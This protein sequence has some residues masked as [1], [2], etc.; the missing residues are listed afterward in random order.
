LAHRVEQP[1]LRKLDGE[2]GEEDEQGAL[3]LLPSSGNFLLCRVSFDRNRV[4][5]SPRRTCWSLYRLK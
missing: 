3:C 1:D 2:V 5:R 4:V